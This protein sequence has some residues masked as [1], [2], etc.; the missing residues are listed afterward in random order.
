MLLNWILSAG[1]LWLIANYVDGIMVNSLV[2]ALIVIAVFS[3]MNVLIKPILGLLTL[4]LNILTLGLFSFVINAVLF[5]A[6]AYFVPGFTV[7]GF[8]PALIGSVCMAVL[9]SLIGTLTRQ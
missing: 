2:T 6:G 5:G 1:G 8:M 3:V 9:S 4:P 7:V